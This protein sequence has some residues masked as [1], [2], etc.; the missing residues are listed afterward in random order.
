MAEMPRAGKSTPGKTSSVSDG[1]REKPPSPLLNFSAAARTVDDDDEMEDQLLARALA[2]Q[3]LNSVMND[4]MP[5]A[6]EVEGPPISLDFMPSVTSF[7]S[8]PQF[9]VDFEEIM[10]RFDEDDKKRSGSSSDQAT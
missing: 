6:S 9:D 10:R 4:V 3:C 8:N 2:P 7:D 1:Q 5:S